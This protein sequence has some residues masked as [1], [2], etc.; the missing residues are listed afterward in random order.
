M[1][2]ET[3]LYKAI[4]DLME[5]REPASRQPLSSEEIL[6]YHQGVLDPDEE[7]ALRERLVGDRNALDTLL[8][9][10]ALA[11]GELSDED[12][13][14]RPEDDQA[15]WQALQQALAAQTVP[16]PS[17]RHR[18]SWRLVDTILVAACLLFGATAIILYLGQQRLRQPFLGTT[19][20]LHFDMV[21][22]RAAT[23]EPVVL[24]Q[25][26]QNIVMRLPHRW[27]DYPAYVVEIRTLDGASLWRHTIPGPANDLS[28]VL[29][30]AFFPSPGSYQVML[31]AEADGKQITLTAFPLTI[32]TP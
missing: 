10:Q 3:A 26:R 24:D 28:L 25:Q 31:A 5:D 30:R 13:F 23:R 22:T 29:D 6:A 1:E 9:L 27:R 14:R 19:Q 11:Q 18:Y 16:P 7:A 15:H 21:D 32:A 17:T 12:V 20:T 8:D 4:S 2:K